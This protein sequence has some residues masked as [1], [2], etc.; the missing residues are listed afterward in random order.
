MAT[1][2][3]KFFGISQFTDKNEGRPVKGVRL[4]VSQL[5]HGELQGPRYFGALNVL[6]VE[7][8]HQ[9]GGAFIVNVP[10]GEQQCGRPGTEQAAL[11]TQQFVP[12]S[13]K[14][15]A[16]SAAAQSNQP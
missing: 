14:V 4:L 2:L 9:L 5:P 10:Q 13:N 12:G 11:K 1:N 15:H 16:G 7:V 6:L 8:G 3:V